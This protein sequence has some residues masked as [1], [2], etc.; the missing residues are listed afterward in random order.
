VEH[1]PADCCSG[2][3]HLAPPR[4]FK[5]PNKKAAFNLTHPYILPVRP[6]AV[7]EYA[8]FLIYRQVGGSR[9]AGHIVEAIESM[10]G[11]D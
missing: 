4:E 3:Q 5:D 9:E 6:P 7:P 8:D 10:L 1:R 11:H 2:D